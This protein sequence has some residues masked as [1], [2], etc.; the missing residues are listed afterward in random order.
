MPLQKGSS[1]STIGSNIK[2]LHTGKTYAHTSSKFGKKDADRQAIAIAM[3]EAGKT[4]GRAFGG[5][6]PQMGGMLAQASNPMMPSNN[7]PAPNA[8][9]QNAIN[10]VAGGLAQPAMGMPP[11]GINAST[12]GLNAGVPGPAGARPFAFGGGVNQ[13]PKTFKGPIVSA[14]PGRTDKHLTKVPSGSFVIPA[15]I[16]SGHG[17]GNT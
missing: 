3:S 13:P 6:A 8:M 5:V 4:K 1:Q 7:M 14:V 9:P 10:G 2:E 12:P 17:Q 11:M 15:D 16:V